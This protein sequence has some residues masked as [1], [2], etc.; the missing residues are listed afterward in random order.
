ML[1]F[2]FAYWSAQC[3]CKFYTKV[4]FIHHYLYNNRFH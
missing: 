4:L 2:F 1:L 3:Y